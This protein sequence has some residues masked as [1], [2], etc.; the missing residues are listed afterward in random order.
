L[1]QPQQNNSDKVGEFMRRLR[2]GLLLGVLVSARSNHS[3]EMATGP[4]ANVTAD[5]LLKAAD[6]SSQWLTR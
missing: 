1:A 5:R 4:A 3:G 6:E 2:L